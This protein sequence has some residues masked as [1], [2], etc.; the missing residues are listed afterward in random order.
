MFKILKLYCILLCAFVGECGLWIEHGDSLYLKINF[1][2]IV[3]VRQKLTVAWEIS[4]DGGGCSQVW[5]KDVQIWRTDHPQ[6][7]NI[8]M[9]GH[10]GH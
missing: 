4:D 5:N 8:R 10:I 3:G 7:V 2:G 9:Y 1:D 6:Y